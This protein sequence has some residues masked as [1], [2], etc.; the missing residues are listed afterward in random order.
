MP[1][2][3]IKWYYDTLTPRMAMF[4]VTANFAISHAMDDLTKEVEEWMKENAPWEDQTGAAR[5]GLTAKKISSGFKQEIYLYHTVDYGIWLEV[6]WN[7]KYAI[8]VPALEHFDTMMSSHF[9]GMLNGLTW[10]SGS[11]PAGLD[12][13][14]GDFGE[15]GGDE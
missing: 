6:R 15:D 10:R 4:V 7:G 13:G 11:L 2:K 5:E 1:T 14:G 3:G 9:T 8:I 12:T